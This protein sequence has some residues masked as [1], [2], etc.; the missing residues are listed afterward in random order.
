MEQVIHP[1]E[2]Q[3]L[4]QKEGTELARQPRTSGLG[5]HA[6]D[7]PQEE[8]LPARS[9][10]LKLHQSDAAFKRKWIQKWVNSAVIRCENGRSW[11][12]RR[13]ATQEAQR[14]RQQ[15]MLRRAKE[16]WQWIW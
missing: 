13:R 12:R 14:Q 10:P 7:Q 8:A 11:G 9:P 1:M 4:L 16:R 3:Q 15:S 5:C 2:S 6:C